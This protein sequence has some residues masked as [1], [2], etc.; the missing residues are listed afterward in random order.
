MDNLPE[1]ETPATSTE[2]KPPKKPRQ[3]P[4]KRRKRRAMKVAAPKRVP[5]KR[6][7]RRVVRAVPAKPSLI[8]TDKAYQLLRDLINLDTPLLNFVVGI[9]TGGRK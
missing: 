1:F 4:T 5:I 7:K 2:P 6:R 8:I 9:A 3:K